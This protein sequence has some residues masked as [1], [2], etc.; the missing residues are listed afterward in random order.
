MVL[1]DCNVVHESNDVML[2]DHIDQNAVKA[3][4]GYLMF[5]VSM[6]FTVC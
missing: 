3:L 2:R 4:S 1:M 5:S 6:F